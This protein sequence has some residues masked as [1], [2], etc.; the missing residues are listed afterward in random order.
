MKKIL[1]FFGETFYELLLNKT[2][3]LIAISLIGLGV[4]QV[5]ADRLVT[6]F[7]MIAFFFSLGFIAF[8]WLQGLIL[9]AVDK[10]LWQSLQDSAYGGRGFLRSK[11]GLYLLIAAVFIL[12]LMVIAL[13]TGNA[14]YMAATIILI[15]LSV[16]YILLFF[17]GARLFH[18]E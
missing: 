6:T 3:V 12:V 18:K 4:W 17:F 15:A 8:C 1:R 11:Q 7:G 2:L 5:G 14:P 16:L 13:A 10:E 9:R